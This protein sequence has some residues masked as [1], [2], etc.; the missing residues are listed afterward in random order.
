MATIDFLRS[1]D[2]YKVLI[3]QGNSHDG[4]DHGLDN[5]L[6]RGVDQEIHEVAH[7]WCRPPFAHNYEFKSKGSKIFVGY[8]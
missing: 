6:R 4:P 8:V 1:S 3:I 7:V 5:L 2:N